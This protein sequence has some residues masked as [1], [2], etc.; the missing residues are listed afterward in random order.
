MII[1][2]R[3]LSAIL[4]PFSETSFFSPSLPATSPLEKMKSP[5]FSNPWQ[6]LGPWE[7]MEPDRHLPLSVMQSG[8]PHLLMSTADVYSRLWKPRVIWI[9]AFHETLPRLLALKVF[10]WL[11]PTLKFSSPLIS[12]ALWTWGQTLIEMWCEKISTQSMHTCCTVSERTFLCHTFVCVL[13][14][15]PIFN[16]LHP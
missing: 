11:L 8:K 12:S 16:C 3:F 2:L 13:K 4:F 7:E 15:F 9:V 6:S 5:S 10:L 1:F 14:L